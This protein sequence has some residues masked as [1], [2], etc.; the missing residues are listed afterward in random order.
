MYTNSSKC[1]KGID[2]EII[3]KEKTLKNVQ[4]ITQFELP[5]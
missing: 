1:E 5:M 2:T 3:G 4:I